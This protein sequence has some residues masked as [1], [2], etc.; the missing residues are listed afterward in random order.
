MY[1]QVVIVRDNRQQRWTERRWVHMHTTMTDKALALSSLPCACAN[2]RRATR[3]ITQLYDAA[4]RPMGL[5]ITQF[6]LLQVLERTG[7]PM[8]Q[9]ALGD[10]LAL[11]STTLTRTLRPLEQATWIRRVEGRDARERRI[12][13]APPGR[14]VLERATPAWERVQRRLRTGLGQRDWAA[15]QKLLTTTLTAARSVSRNKS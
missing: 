6:T 7:E 1:I 3:A 12:E 10:F 5:R 13:L 11:D 2:M 9:A 15:L 14:R 4:L 8:T